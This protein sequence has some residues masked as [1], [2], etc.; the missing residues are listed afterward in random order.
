M[1]KKW[2]YAFAGM[3]KNW[4]Y[5]EVRVNEGKR[6]KRGRKSSI[7][8]RGCADSRSESVHPK[9]D[10]FCPFFGGFSVQNVTKWTQTS[11]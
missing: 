7:V 1:S 6:E 4:T 5:I 8:M 2:I 3:D 9:S 10:K 11:V